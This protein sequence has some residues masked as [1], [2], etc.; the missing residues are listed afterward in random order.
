MVLP[1]MGCKAN[2]HPERTLDNRIKTLSKCIIRHDGSI[3]VQKASV[4]Q[5]GARCPVAGP[6]EVLRSFPL[7]LQALR[8]IVSLDDRRI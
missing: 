4:I 3:L 1:L 6:G 5:V 8:P 7:S 2:M